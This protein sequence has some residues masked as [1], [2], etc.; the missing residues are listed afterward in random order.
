MYTY[1]YYVNIQHSCSLTSLQRESS[2]PNSLFM[3]L[4]GYWF[5]TARS[6]A[7]CR[8]FTLSGRNQSQQVEYNSKS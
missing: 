7:N 6:L 1:I 3:L 5:I 2:N 4:F 8:L